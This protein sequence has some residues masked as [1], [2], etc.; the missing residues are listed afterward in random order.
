MEMVGYEVA[1]KSRSRFPRHRLDFEARPI[2]PRPGEKLQRLLLE[3]SRPHHG[4][5]VL[6]VVLEQG[7]VQ[8]WTRR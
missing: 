6:L 3:N 7:E 1:A 8:I 4:A 5:H 2:G